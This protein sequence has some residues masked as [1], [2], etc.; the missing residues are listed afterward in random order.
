MQGMLLNECVR[1]RDRF[2]AM[3]WLMASRNPAADFKPRGIRAGAKSEK[4]ARV[5]AREL[6][7]PYQDG[8]L[9]RGC[10]QRFPSL[11]I[12]PGSD[13]LIRS[14][15]LKGSSATPIMESPIERI[16]LNY[17]VYTRAVNPPAK[18]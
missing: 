12:I 6:L 1:L 18:R 7:E 5:D 17:T 13:S 9:Q 3:R 2:F 14:N 11:S 8:R 4:L 15:T 10:D 16:A